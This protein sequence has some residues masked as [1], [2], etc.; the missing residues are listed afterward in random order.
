MFYKRAPLAYIYRKQRIGGLS[1]KAKKKGED[2]ALI[3]EE[4]VE[5]YF[6]LNKQAKEI[7]KEL[8]RLKKTFNQ[9][10]DLTVGKN[11]KGEI[12]FNNFIVQRQ[13][14][15]SEKFKEGEAVQ[16]LEEL[17]L[18]DCIKVEKSVDVD[19]VNAAVT[20]G[21]IDQDVLVDFK[22]TKQSAAIFVREL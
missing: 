1:L 14:R 2:Q 11:Q 5:Q 7:E 18:V 19:K 4:M 17:N 8:T 16:K 3:T 22:E 15:Q 10:F 9:Y 12:S 6:Q 21:L 13:I 20:L